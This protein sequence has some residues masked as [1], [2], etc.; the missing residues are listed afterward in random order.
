MLCTPTSGF[1]DDVTVGHMETTHGT[2]SLG[3]RV[4][5]SFGSSF[6]TGSS[7]HRVITLNRCETRVFPVFEKM[8]KMQNVHLK[9]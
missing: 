3:H 6:T 5:R 7:G 1:M 2:G 4:N 9:C 8:P